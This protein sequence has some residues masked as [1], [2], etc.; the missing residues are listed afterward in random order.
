MYL[1]K[2][3]A[4]VF[5]ASVRLSY[6]RHKGLALPSETYVVVAEHD[7]FGLSRGP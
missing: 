1:Y 7:S 3:E 4:V 2:P 5:P 6:G